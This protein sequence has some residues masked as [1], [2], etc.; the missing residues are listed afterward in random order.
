MNGG[1]MKVWGIFIIILLA[2]PLWAEA[3]ARE[4]APV[5][6]MKAY[7]QSYDVLMENIVNIKT[8]GYKS[9][10]SAVSIEDSGQ[11]AASRLTRFTKG[12]LEET[13]GNLDVAIEGDGFFVVQLE[14]NSGFSEQ[15]RRKTYQGVAFT[16]DGRFQ[17]DQE[18]R[19]VTMAGGYPVLSKSG[20]IYVVPFSGQGDAKVLISSQGSIIQDNNLLGVFQVVTFEKPEEL[21]RINGVFFRIPR[22]R[23]DIAMTELE[24][25]HVRVGYVEASNVDLS[26]Q[27]VELPLNSRKYDANSKSLQILR[28]TAQ[29]AR[30]MG[31]VQ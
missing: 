1:R 11:I 27:L 3:P 26:R 24:D 4:Q 6:A 28:K 31:R 16:R 29:T 7:E 25:V 22:G 2:M 18:N 30:E 17:I 15:N 9:M 21:E 5:Q 19:L 10:D 13:R 14:Q 20:P 12:T 23:T 8:P